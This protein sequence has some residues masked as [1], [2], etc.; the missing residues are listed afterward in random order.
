MGADLVV[1]R[2][3]RTC[4]VGMCGVRMSGNGEMKS[5]AKR[6]IPHLEKDETS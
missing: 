2:G 4:R 5:N 3:E 1:M 6:S